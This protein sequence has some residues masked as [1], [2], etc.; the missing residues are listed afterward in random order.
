MTAMEQIEFISVEARKL[1]MKYGEYVEKFGHTLPKPKSKA[2]KARGGVWHNKKRKAI[3]LTCQMCG[4]P[5]VAKS[6]IAQFCEECKRVRA[7]AATQEWK[8]K[9]P[10]AERNAKQPNQERIKKERA[11]KKKRCISCG[12][13]FTTKGRGKYCTACAKEAQKRQIREYM[14]RRWEKLKA[15]KENEKIQ[16]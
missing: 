4:K 2:H 14:K 13:E 6:P 5:F 10:K 12:T 9:Q 16:E 1:G 11:I 7:V 8:A 15:A 3:D